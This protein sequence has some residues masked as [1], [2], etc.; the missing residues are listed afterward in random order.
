MKMTFLFPSQVTQFPGVL[1]QNSEN[2]IV[3]KLIAK[4]TEIL[5]MNPFPIDL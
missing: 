3:D 1:Q 5:Q 4:A 2:D